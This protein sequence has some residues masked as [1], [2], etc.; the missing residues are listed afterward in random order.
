MKDKESQH[1]KVQE[2]I[3]C[4]AESD[5]LREMSLISAEEDSSEAAVKWLALSALHGIN[6]NASSISILKSSD[7]SVKVTAEYR[8]AELPSP[9]EAAGEKIIQDIRDITHLEGNA[10]ASLLSMGVRGETL[11]LQVRINRMGKEE[12]VK[13]CLP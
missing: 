7:G 2:M 10:G 12:T 3:D 9:G 1:K 13:L 5:P 4:Y 8:P 6:M 11:D